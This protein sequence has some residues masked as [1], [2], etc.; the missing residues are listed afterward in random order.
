MMSTE[1]SGRIRLVFVAVALMFG[2]LTARLWQLQVVK[3]TVYARLSQ[4]NRLRTEKVP[5]PRGI[6]YDRNGKPLVKNSPYY[7]VALLPEMARKADLAA[8]SGFLGMNPREVADI[9]GS[10]KDP[11]EPIRIKGGLSFDE[12]AFIEARISD[13]PGLVIEA[14]ETRHYIYG[15]MGAHLI[16]YLGKLNPQQISRKDYQG[17]PRKAFTGQWGV[18]RMYDSLLRGEP[19]T[20]VIEVDAMGRRLSLLKEAEPVTGKDLYLSIDMDLQRAAEEAFGARVGAL[21]AIKPGTGEVL[22]LVSRPSYDPNLFSRGIGYESWVSLR[23]DKRYPLLNRALQSHYPPGST[24]KIVTALAALEEGIATPRS[25]HTC[26][27][28]IKKGRWSFRCWRRAGHGTLNMMGGMTQS[29]DVYFYRTGERTGIDNIARYARLLGLG[30]ESGLGLI[31]EKSGL[32][33]DREWKQRVKGLSWYP[34]NTYNTAIGQGFVLTTPIQLAQMT[35]TLVNG[36]YRHPLRLLRAEEFPLPAENLGLDPANVEF[37][38]K[39]L[40]GVVIGKK[41]TGRAANSRFVEVGG[42][43]GTAQVVAQ[44][45]I[46]ESELP[47]HLRDHAWFVAFAPVENPE[48]AMAVFVENG[49]HGGATAAPIARKAIEAYLAK[50]E[51]KPRPREPEEIKTT[52]GA[53]VRT[54]APRAWTD[55]LLSPRILNVISSGEPPVPQLP[56]V[57]LAPVRPPEAVNSTGPG[58]EPEQEST[59]VEPPVAP[60]VERPAETPSAPRNA[61]TPSALESPE[62]ETE[63]GD[64]PN[65]MD[66][67]Q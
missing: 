36:G 24:F 17:V 18:E 66:E 30:S 44:K 49:G 12:V 46:R 54:I 21:A 40:R 57:P 6:I 28:F 58:T 55:L 25:K 33:P 48:I 43:T 65:T 16:G 34:G 38:K 10:V 4:G 32:I 60:P 51:T 5:S 39:T 1:L 15:P 67:R 27:G 35:A 61:A 47:E 56:S 20:R 59:V 62:G 19:G 37:L 41:G 63:P 13:H 22:A 11:I 23:E 2:L 29:C 45:K 31:K 7:F 53:P 8:I 14:E 50:Q 26:K 52:V 64:M 42:K 3:G 9:V